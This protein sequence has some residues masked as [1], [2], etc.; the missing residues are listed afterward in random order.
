MPI[1]P[2]GS[3]RNIGLKVGA[4][5]TNPGYGIDPRSMYASDILMCQNKLIYIHISEW[6]I[7]IVG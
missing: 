6:F 4:A 2:G 5:L 7:K 3:I 1:G